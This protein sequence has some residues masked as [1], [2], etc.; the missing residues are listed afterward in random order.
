M[1]AGEFDVIDID[2]LGPYIRNNSPGAKNPIVQVQQAGIV[3]ANAPVQ[4]R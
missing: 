1:K 2:L 3:A 4:T